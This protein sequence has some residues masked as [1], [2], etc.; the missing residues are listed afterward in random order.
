[1]SSTFTALICRDRQ[2]HVLHVGD[3]RLHRLRG[4]QLSLLTTDH[5]AG[6]GQLN[7]LTR[8]IGTESEIRIDYLNQP[9]ELHDRFLLCTDG[10]FKGI[11]HKKLRETMMR[12]AAAAETCRDLVEQ[13]LSTNVGDNASAIVV[14]LIELPHPEYEEMLTRCLA[15][16]SSTYRNQATLSTAFAWNA[17]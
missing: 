16:Q 2:I 4:D 8:A 12:R 11:G 9:S 3:S 7:R 6:P 17:S 5:T 14:D 15:M 13:A 10:L 1:M